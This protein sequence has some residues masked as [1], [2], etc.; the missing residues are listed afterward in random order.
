[1]PF[2][3]I[4]DTLTRAGIAV[5]R[6]D[7]RGVGKS[8]GDNAK[9][10]SFNK[11]DDVHTE[12]AWL[13]KQNGILA[14]RIMLVGYSEGGLIAPMVAAKDPAIAALVTRQVP[15]FQGWKL[16][17]IK[18]NSQ[19][20]GIRGYPPATGSRRSQKNSRRP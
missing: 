10:T 18:S 16:R 3:D 13:R 11:A 7:D 20:S 14:S 1:M 5:L 15:V 2:R 4:A 9:F 17:G 19:Y 6:V 12:V 8:S